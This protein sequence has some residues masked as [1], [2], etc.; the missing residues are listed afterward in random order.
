MIDRGAMGRGAV[1]KYWLAQDFIRSIAMDTIKSV[2]FAGGDI[3][4]QIVRWTGG[5]TVHVN[6][7][8]TDWT[9]AKRTLPQY[10]YLAVNGG[11]SSSIER[12]GG[13]IVEQSAGPGGRYVN[14]RGYG[15][16]NELALAPSAK[17]VEYLGGRTFRL[18]VEWQVGA[19]AP[20][21]LAVFIH[22]THE[23]SK[24]SDKIAF[25]G[26]LAP[27]VGTSRWRGKVLTGAGRTV[28]IPPE[29]GPG[30]YGI[31]IGLWDPA[32]GRRYALRG[33]DDGTQRYRLGSLVV[34]GAGGKVTGVR[35]VPRKAAPRAAPR[36][37]IKRTPI[38]FGPAQTAGAFRCRR[39]GKTITVTPL[40]DLAPF[41]IAIRPGRLGVKGKPTS[42]A[43]LA[44]D[45]RPTRK[46]PF[47]VKDGAMIFRT[48][49]GEFAYR[50]T[51]SA[52]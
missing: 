16:G 48:D 41:A 26:D 6:R 14:A 18:T 37:N 33:E 5:A 44:R 45:G 42:I 19:P 2:T 24:S 47:T 46:V 27:R 7:G 51:L 10:G 49:K 34:E 17:R 21:D 1:R 43:A 35:L 4:R 25:Q 40:P 23:R 50:I 32:G 36:W 28:H 52:P 15:Q 13:V 22:F 38:D 29:W 9:I 31:G 30:T 12:I 8:K 11:V 3:H 20:K 39:E